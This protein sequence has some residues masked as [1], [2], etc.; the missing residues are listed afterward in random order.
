MYF[1]LVLPREIYR[2]GYLR[3]IVVV[4]RLTDVSGLAVPF[5]TQVEFIESH[6]IAY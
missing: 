5:D 2:A 3:L 1:S 4:Y 6:A